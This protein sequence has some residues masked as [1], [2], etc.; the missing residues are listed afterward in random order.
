MAGDSNKS[1]N[2]SSL[3]AALG[4]Q[5]GASAPKVF[6]TSDE[7][8]LAS[9]GIAK[10]VFTF[11]TPP[12]VFTLEDVKVT[13]GAV[14]SLV[15]DLF[16]PH[17]YT[18]QF[19]GGLSNRSGMSTIQVESPRFDFSTYNGNPSNTLTIKNVD[20]Q[21]LPTVGFASNNISFAEGNDGKKLATFTLTLSSAVSGEVTAFYSTDKKTFG[22]AKAGEDFV[23]T[24][25][26][27]VFAAGEKTKTVTVEIL[28][29][30][31]YE[32]NEY[33]YLDITSAKNADV[34]IN[35]AEGLRSSWVMAT[36]LNDDLNA[37]PTVSFASNNASVVEGNEGTKLFQFTVNLSA[38]SREVITADY[39]TEKKTYGTAK[40]NIDYIPTTGTLT[41]AA[42]ETSKT[43]LVPIIGDKDFEADEYFYLDL[44]S[45]SGAD[46]MVNGAEG[47]K[48]SWVMATIKNDDANNKPTVSFASNNASIVE[49][50]EGTKLFQFKVNLSAASMETVT[51]EYSTEKKTFGTAKANAD[52]IPA[53][54][55]L[56]FA[57]GETSK[58][59]LVE[60]VGDTAYE[61]SEYFYLDL[62]SAR[63]ADIVTN[64][65]E[66]LKSAWVMATISNDDVA[67]GKNQISG[68]YGSSAKDT[69]GG[70]A[71]DDLIDGRGGSDF[72]TGYA[73]NDTFAF[74]ASYAAKDFTSA[75]RILDFKDGFDRIGLRGELAFADLIISDAKE[76]D[77]ALLSLK[78]GEALAV[79]IGV[80]ASTIDMGDFVQL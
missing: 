14:T 66:G 38:A 42:G 25:G 5:N 59:I 75:A 8:L 61:A 58:T 30:T 9:N 36:I 1:N 7:S 15:Q 41:F 35:G 74:A 80:R 72:I 21:I 62:L 11:S 27:V 18:A 24:K 77:G 46:V 76:G 2:S 43:I 56:T 69:L 67:G 64:G 17:I 40:A 28:G 47:L 19:I 68:V 39:S 20:K 55:T 32:S 12:A 45:S 16:N 37:K 73:G 3:P 4:R 48:S 70:S 13:N 79:L 26:S 10:L 60:I 65:A 49:G 52:Y 51:V 33:F 71:L 6:I 57:P 63:G 23:A 29:D 78:T 44:T 22:T 31:R 50:N 54:G 34:V 53:K